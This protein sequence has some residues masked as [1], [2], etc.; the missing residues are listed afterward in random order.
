MSDLNFVLGVGFIADQYG[1]NQ[2]EQ[3]FL[4]TGDE[5][6]PRTS[7]TSGTLAL[8]TGQQRFSFF[9]ARKSFVS[10]QGRSLTGAT[11]SDGTSTLS[12]F[13]VY[14][15]DALGNV[16]LIAATA[17]DATLW[18]VANTAFTR[19]WLAPFAYVTGNR[20]AWSEVIVSAGTTP[21]FS[22]WSSGVAAELATTPRISGLLSGQTDLIASTTIGSMSNSGAVPYGV[23]LP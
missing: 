11:A 9:T 22:G 20:Y 15:V 4:T 19:S 12:K 8:T 21:S 10:S 5:S 7:L 18:T 3:Q 14:S 6:A 2:I 1:L 17:H 16:V 23:V 13:G